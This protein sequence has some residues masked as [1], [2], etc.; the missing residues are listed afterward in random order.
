MESEH[1]ISRRKLLGL[2]LAG[3]SA[4]AF[5]LPLYEGLKFAEKEYGLISDYNNSWH[6]SKLPSDEFL[7]RFEEQT[8]H[9]QFAASFAPERF[10]V[11][12]DELS[13]APLEFAR[14]Q[15][16]AKQS[17]DFMIHDLG[18][19][20]VRMGIRWNNTTHP[21]GTFDPS[22]YR[23]FLETC[24]ANGVNMTLDVGPIKNQRWPLLLQTDLMH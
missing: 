13:Q 20:D 6:A 7:N 16:L 14:N 5:P 9:V 8:G 18:V 15:E 17:L 2:G 3:A 11:T 4:I 21:N 19:T 22:I 10:N 23:P 1:H 24:F 12:F